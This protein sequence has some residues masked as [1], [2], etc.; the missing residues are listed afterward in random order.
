MFVIEN[1]VNWFLQKEI[2]ELVSRIAGEA[3]GAAAAAARLSGAELL[4]ASCEE[5][6]HCLH[7]R[8]GPAVK[9]Q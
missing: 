3:A 7:L 1:V 4:M 2:S 8:L 5:L 9:V 6:V